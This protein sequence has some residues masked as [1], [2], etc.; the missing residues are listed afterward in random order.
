MENLSLLIAQVSSSLTVIVGIYAT[1]LTIR[2]ARGLVDDDF[3]KLVVYSSIFLVLSIIGT[4]SMAYYHITESRVESVLAD[5]IWYIFMFLA[6]IF[7]LY[8]SYKIADFGKRLS[9]SGSLPRSS[10]RKRKR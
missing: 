4:A 1:I 10:K 2:A 6:L 7:S 3:K 8:E 9:F 5:N